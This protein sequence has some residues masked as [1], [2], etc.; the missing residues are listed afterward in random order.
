[1]IS[2]ENIIHYR[3]ASNSPHL[4]NGSGSKSGTKIKTKQSGLTTSK[5]K[6]NSQLS[7][8]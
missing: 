1:V 8:G 2:P 7:M 6:T 3:K 4:S 5:T